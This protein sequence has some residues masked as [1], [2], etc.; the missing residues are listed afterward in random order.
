MPRFVALLRAVNLGGT[1]KIA[2][3]ELKEFFSVVG[4]GNPTTLLASGNV[5]FESSGDDPR[6]YET[7][8]E[9]ESPLRIGLKTEY[10]VRSGREWDGIVAANPFSKE[11]V[12]DPGHLVVLVLKGRPDP[13]AAGKLQSAIRGR[14]YFS[15]ADRHAYLVYPDGIGT[16]KLTMTA[17]ERSLGTRATGRNWNTARKIRELLQP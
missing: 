4:F 3:S 14:E 2:M 7:L 17:I 11:A 9:T 15:L 6:T 13:D 8:L 12:A 5:V 1:G 16:S 10:F